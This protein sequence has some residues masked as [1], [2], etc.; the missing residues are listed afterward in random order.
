MTRPVDLIRCTLE[1]MD[2]GRIARAHVLATEAYHMLLWQDAVTTHN[3]PPNVAEPD[4]SHS[5]VMACD[6]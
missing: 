1:A 5:S 6:E 4:V 3:D 2:A